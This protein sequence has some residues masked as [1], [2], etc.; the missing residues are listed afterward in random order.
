MFGRHVLIATL[1]ALGLACSQD[2]GTTQPTPTPEPSGTNTP[3]PAPTPDVGNGSSMDI[4]VDGDLVINTCRAVVAQGS[5]QVAVSDANGFAAGDRILIVQVQD[6]FA[7]SG[8]TTNVAAADLAG[9]WEI[10][11]VSAVDGSFLELEAELKG[12]YRSNVGV[13]ESAQVCTMPEFTDV[14]I[15]ATGRITAPAWDGQTG[16]IVAFYANGIVTNNG[17]IDVEAL[18]FRGGVL[19]QNN[20]GEDV[21]LEDTTNGQGGGKAEG[22]DGRS[23]AGFGRG[24]MGNAA[25]G[26][27]AHNAGGGGG[28]NGAAG[29]LG[30]RQNPD[31]GQV[32]DT[33]GRPGGGIGP[34]PSV[35]LSF[36][37]GGGAGQQN[38]GN[39]G[40]GGIGGG[41]AVMIVNDLTGNGSI[42]ADGETGG[43]ANGDGAGGGGAGGTILIQ[44]LSSDFTGTVTAVGG[45]GGD[46]TGSNGDGPG[47]GGA[48]GRLELAPDIISN[49]NLVY[50]GGLRGENGGNNT[51]Q[52]GLDGALLVAEEIQ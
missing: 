40:V 31:Q 44:V 33:A 15:N 47:G 11:R 21:V 7:T 30:S 27:N 48:G 45:G 13:G 10:V 39:G 24:A 19:A 43:T 17:A 36:G 41:L 46:V 20:G 8:V 9:S 50:T 1:T 23:R 16:G 2:V 5:Q 34:T 3:T 32:D 12:T 38:N 52:P 4:V 26:G 37:G 35:L 14:T 51:A 42:D 28:G 29:G 49:A 18:G 22:L 6:D 25:G